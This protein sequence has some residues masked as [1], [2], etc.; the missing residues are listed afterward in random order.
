[1][2]VTCPQISSEKKLDRQVI[3]GQ[4]DGWMDIDNKGKGREKQMIKQTDKMPPVTWVKG[5][6][7]VCTSFMFV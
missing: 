2:Q 5:Y 6:R 1:M 7:Y 4:T 3:D